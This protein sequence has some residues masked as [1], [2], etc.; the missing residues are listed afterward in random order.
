MIEAPPDLISKSVYD[1]QADYR[2]YVKRSAELQFDFRDWLM[3][4]GNI[5]KRPLVPGELCF[6]MA[7]TGHGK[8]AILQ[9]IAIAARSH[10]ILMFEMELP[11]TLCFERFAAIAHEMDQEAVENIYKDESFVTLGKFDHIYVCEKTRLTID[12]MKELIDYDRTYNQR[13]YTILVVDYIGLMDNKSKGSRYEAVSKAAEDL[14][15]L[16]KETNTIVIAASQIHRKNEDS[17]G[18]SLHDAKDSGS[19]ENSCGL[20]I[21]A[22]RD[23]DSRGVMNF[24]VLK[25]TKGG[26]EWEPIQVNFDGPSLKITAKAQDWHEFDP[27][28]D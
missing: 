12:H 20:L 19:I 4:L 10:E 16:A 17:D 22:W 25:N 3:P 13:D 24:R 9:N 23:N 7:D 1:L 21:G 11:G 14:K 27:D 8:T 6:I 28:T 15:V 18:I 5:V 26:G 2:A